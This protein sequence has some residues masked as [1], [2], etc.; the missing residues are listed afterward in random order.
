[1]PAQGKAAVLAGWGALSHMPWDRNDLADAAVEFTDCNCGIAADDEH[2]VLDV[3]I[4]DVQLA[5]EVA[6]LADQT[7]G[8]T[9]L[10]RVGLHP[11]TMRVYGNGSPGRIRSSKPH[12]IEIM[13]GSGMVIAYG[14]H[15]VTQRPYQWVAG[16][17]P[18]TLPA[19]STDIPAINH[20][21]L[22]RFLTEAGRL[23]ARAHYLVC[24]RAPSRQRAADRSA[25]LDIRQRLR[26]D[27]MRIGFERAAIG[28]LRAAVEGSRHIT[29]FEVV[30]SAAGRGWSEERIIRLFEAHFAGC[31]DGVSDDAFRRI[32]AT[33][34]GGT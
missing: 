15:P 3:D 34:F 23:L 2:V 4:L 9:P 17:S 28:V 13:S 30:A 5:Y 26:I 32:L 14:I 20:H 31:W 6:G 22:Q 24:G 1:M 29:A 12:P 33:C 11:K 10:I 8:A 19:D 21:Q 18:L 16:A 7:L 25:F 27:A